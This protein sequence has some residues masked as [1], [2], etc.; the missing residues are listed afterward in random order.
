MIRHKFHI[1]YMWSAVNF[2]IYSSMFELLQK[3]LPCNLNKS[4]FVIFDAKVENR[5]KNVFLIP[6]ILCWASELDNQKLRKIV[7]LTPETHLLNFQARK[8]RKHFD[9]WTRKCQCFL[10]AAIPTEPEF[11]HPSGR[12]FKYMQNVFVVTR[13]K[14]AHKLFYIILLTVEGIYK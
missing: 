4:F 12:K 1:R 14:Q 2:K 7:F 6:K 5:R 10:L 11:H 8:S 13:D 3:W 9:L